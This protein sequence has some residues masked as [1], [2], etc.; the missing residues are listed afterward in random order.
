MNPVLFLKKSLAAKLMLAFILVTVPPMLVASHVA[1]RLVNV[2][3][4][5]NIGRWLR[6][7]SRYL[8]RIIGETEEEIAA[9]HILLRPRLAQGS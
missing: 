8:F 2:T 1:T 6:E 9:A 5:E 3:A 7:A 4:N